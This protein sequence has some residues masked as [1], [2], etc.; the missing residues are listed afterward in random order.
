MKNEENLEISAKIAEEANCKDR[1]DSLKATSDT[2]NKQEEH[3]SYRS[4]CQ[5][6]Y[7]CAI[8]EKELNKVEQVFFK[9][10]K[11]SIILSD[12]Y[13]CSIIIL[14]V[15]DANRLMKGQDV[16]HLH[17]ETKILQDFKVLVNGTGP[18]YNYD[19]DQSKVNNVPLT[20][21]NLLSGDYL[22][23]E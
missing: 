7:V 17:S 5:T 23:P 1:S 18:A 9:R 13:T 22:D 15:R 4:Q 8:N 2:H 12:K 10:P 20:E 16:P 3:K 11:N 14:C 19:G 6:R 21:A